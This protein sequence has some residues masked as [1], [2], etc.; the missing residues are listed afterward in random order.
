MQRPDGLSAVAFRH[1]SAE[2]PDT[3]EPAVPASR[4]RVLRWGAIRP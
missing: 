4:D 3:F 2:Y 1:G